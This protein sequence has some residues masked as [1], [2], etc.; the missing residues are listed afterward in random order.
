LGPDEWLFVRDPVS[1]ADGRAAYLYNN[2]ISGQLSARGYGVLDDVSEV[3]IL[4]ETGGKQGRTR[5]TASTATVDGV[6]VPLEPYNALAKALRKYESTMP[7]D[8]A[9]A[10]RVVFGEQVR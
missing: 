8:L 1:E 3:V 4:K 9:D 2:A 10:F 6:L 7:P 5:A